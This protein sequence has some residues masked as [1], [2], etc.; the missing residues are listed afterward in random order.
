MF[1]CCRI[2]GNIHFLLL[3]E[4]HIPKNNTIFIRVILWKKLWQV[5][6]AYF[7]P[8]GI[9]EH[10]VIKWYK[11]ALQAWVS[12]QEI[13]FIIHLEMRVCLTCWVTLFSSNFPACLFNISVYL[14]YSFTIYFVPLLT[15]YLPSVHID[16]KQRMH[17]KILTTH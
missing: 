9:F 7:A 6:H 3:Q 16:A 2:P 8:E 17:E 12:N 13:K 4:I 1:S 11:S 10:S 15:F 5:E 14:Y